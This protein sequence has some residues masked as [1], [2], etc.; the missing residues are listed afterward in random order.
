MPVVSA[1]RNER[2]SFSG[3]YAYSVVE[4]SVL[5]VTAC[6]SDLQQLKRRKARK[7]ARD[8]YPFLGRGTTLCL[9]TLHVRDISGGDF[10]TL[11][12]LQQCQVV[13]RPN[14]NLFIS[15]LRN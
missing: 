12:E 4:I 1:P 2:A 7:P 6:G 14:L 13:E 3:N 5:T 10:G 15:T 9:P 11:Q 8:A